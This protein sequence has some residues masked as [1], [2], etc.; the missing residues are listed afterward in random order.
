MSGSVSLGEVETFK[1]AA[2]LLVGDDAADVMRLLVATAAAML[3]DTLGSQAAAMEHAGGIGPA[4]TEAVAA[5]ADARLAGVK[6][7]GRA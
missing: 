4:V 1:A 5:I 2:V 6:P 7:E 3:L